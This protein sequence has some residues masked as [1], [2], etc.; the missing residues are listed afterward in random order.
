[1]KVP[2]AWAQFTTSISEIWS[3]TGAKLQEGFAAL[4]EF[5]KGIING[6]ISVFE[7]YINSLIRG[8]NWVIGKINQFKVEVPNYDI[9]GD[10]AGKTFGFNFP[11]IP[12]LSIP[13]L[14]EG[15]IVDRA[16]LAMIGEAGPEAVVPLDKGRMGAT[17]NITVNAGMGAEG[18]RIGE[19]IIREIKR[20]ERQSGPVFASA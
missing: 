7:G 10:L 14:A 18:G 6:M 9:F 16:T 3:E 8:I 11:E 13:R 1:V 4:G 20:Y 2:E 15:G 17:Y 5:F 19:A 12:E